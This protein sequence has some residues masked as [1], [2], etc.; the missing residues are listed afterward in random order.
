MSFQNIELPLSKYTSDP[1][2]SNLTFGLELEFAVATLPLGA[3]DPEPRD[4]RQV[5]GLCAGAYDCRTINLKVHITKTLIETGFLAEWSD[6]R[7]VYS[8]RPSEE[9]WVVKD[10][11]SILGPKNENYDWL[12]IEI[13]SPAFYWGDENA[14]RNIKVLL[15]V[16]KRTYRIN[17][18]ESCGLHVHVGN[19]ME[20][21]AFETIRNLMATLWTFEKQIETFHPQHR[22]MNTL[23]CPSFRGFTRLARCNTRDGKLDARRGLEDILRCGPDFGGLEYLTSLDD[24]SDEDGRMAYHLGDV[25]AQFAISDHYKRTV[26]FRQHESTLDYK[27]IEL[28]IRFC[29]R[30]MEFSHDAD[31]SVLFPFLRKHVDLSVEEF[32]LQKVLHSIGGI[33][34]GHFDPLQIE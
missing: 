18:N 31:Q 17:V 12:Q 26:E 1:P 13:V 3:I 15:S 19:G 14:L 22:R 23:M 2:K 21:F 9:S 6:D 7:P 32:P 5:I 4:R 29:A 16:L 24:D 11:A 8:K 30:T 34:L 20:G 33:F 25:G 28:W 10:D 27:R